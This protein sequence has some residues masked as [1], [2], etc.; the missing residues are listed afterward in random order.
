MVGLLLLIIESFPPKERRSISW[1]GFV[2]VFLGFISS[3]RRGAKAFG[4]FFPLVGLGSIGMDAGWVGLASNS[5]PPPQVRF[6]FIVSGVGIVESY[7][8]NR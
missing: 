5:P 3:S 4:F 2:E 8:G 6:F 1:S 7:F